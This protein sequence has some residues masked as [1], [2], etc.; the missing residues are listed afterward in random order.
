MTG[1]A[2]CLLRLSW[3]DIGSNLSRRMAI[4]NDSTFLITSTSSRAGE[5]RSWLA[6]FYLNHLCRIVSTRIDHPNHCLKA[7]PHER[8]GR[9]VTRLRPTRYSGPCRS[10]RQCINSDQAQY[11]FKPVEQ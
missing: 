7:N 9:K 10:D 11:R 6:R 3:L 1:R 4:V 5:R 8:R 2:A